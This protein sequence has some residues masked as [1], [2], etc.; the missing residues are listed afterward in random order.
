MHRYDIEIW[1]DGDYR[2]S[3]VITVDA[4]TRTQAAAK[5]RKQYSGCE[6]AWVNMIG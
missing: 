4:R 1:I 5:A 6:V 3:R 2:N